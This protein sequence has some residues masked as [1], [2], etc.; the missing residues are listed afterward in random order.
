MNQPSVFFLRACLLASRFGAANPFHIYNY[1][2]AYFY[3]TLA[4]SKAA[5]TNIDK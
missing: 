4:I 3:A 5:Y 2:S 1:Y